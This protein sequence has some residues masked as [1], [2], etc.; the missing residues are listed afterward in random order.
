MIT[1]MARDS[2]ASVGPFNTV[3]SSERSIQTHMK[4]LLITAFVLFSIIMAFALLADSNFGVGA[5]YDTTHVYVQPENFDKFVAS[6]LAT[7]GGTTTKQGVF[8]VTPIPR[9]EALH[10]HATLAGHAQTVDRESV[11]TT[12]LQAACRARIQ[13]HEFAEQAVESPF[14][15]AVFAHGVGRVHLLSDVRLV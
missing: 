13:V 6:L 14:G 4:R 10:D 8:T 15:I 11:C 9:L 5:Q 3:R 7:F 12:L 2:V 1:N